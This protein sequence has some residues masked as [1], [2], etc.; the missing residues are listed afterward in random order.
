[1]TPSDPGDTVGKNQAIGD[2]NI[3]TSPAKTVISDTDRASSEAE[4]WKPDTTCPGDTQRLFP[5]LPGY[6][7]PFTRVIEPVKAYSEV[8]QQVGAD[9]AVPTKT[10]V[11]RK[12]RLKEVTIERG[13]KG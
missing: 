5:V 10:N 9:G 12:T 8:V 1:M 11:M 2:G 7:Y 6:G 4:P 3:E 13:W